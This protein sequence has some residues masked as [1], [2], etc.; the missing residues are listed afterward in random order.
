MTNKKT[1]VTVDWSNMKQRIDRAKRKMSDEKVAEHIVDSI[2]DNIRNN[3][4]S[5][6]TGK[7]YRKLAALT[8]KHR[9]Y[10]AKHNRTHSNY[11]LNKPNLT[12]TGKLLDSIKAKVKMTAKGVDYSINVSGTHPRYRGVSGS[13]GKSL[14]NE[15]IREQ[16]ASIK[17]DPLG[18]SKKMRKEILVF[19]KQNLI[20]ALYWG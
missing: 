18:I 4:I 17:R 9:K 8:I 20:K 2:V 16:L 6:K 10:L 7:K 15:E 11:S 19:I 12:I 3:S 1:R 14:T 5:P 13:I